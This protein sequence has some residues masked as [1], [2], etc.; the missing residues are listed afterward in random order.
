MKGV[1]GAYLGEE[2]GPRNSSKGKMGGNV[3][4]A[5]KG[6]KKNVLSQHRGYRD[7]GKGP[8]RE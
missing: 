1:E 8:A 3:I 4:S 2:T 6:K 5:R 7:P